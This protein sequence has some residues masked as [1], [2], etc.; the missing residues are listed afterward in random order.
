VCQ[1]WEISASEVVYFTDTLT[2][3][4]EVRGIVK[5]VIGCSWGVHPREILSQLLPEDLILDEFGDIYQFFP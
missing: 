4:I 3:V 5:T 1:D 2:D